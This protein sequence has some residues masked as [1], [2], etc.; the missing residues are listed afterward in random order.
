MS[1]QS[2]KSSLVWK[3]FERGS[4]QAVQFLVGII[5]ARL[6]T[7]SVFGEVALLTIFVSIAN[8]FVLSGLS[9]AIV[10]KKEL[11]DIEVT[12]V[13]WYCMCV[14]II[15][16]AILFFSSESIAS[17]YKMTSLSLHLKVM[18]LSLFPGALNAIQIACLSKEMQFKKQ[19]YCNTVAVLFSGSLGLYMAYTGYGA[20]ALIFQQ[21]SYQVVACVVMWLFVK[22]RPSFVFSIKKT[23]P[24]LFYGSKLLFSNITDTV[25]RNL[26]SLVIGKF[27]NSATL[28]F[29]NKGKMFPMVVSDNIDGSIQSV[30]LPAFSKHQDNVEDLKAYLRKTI[31]LST[32]L[33][34]PSMLLLAAASKSVIGICLG[35]AWMECVPFV[36]LFCILTMLFPIQTTSVQALNAIGLSGITMRYRIRTRVIGVSLLF[37]FLYLFKTPYSIVFASIFTE[38]CGILILIPLNKKYLTYSFLELSKDLSSPLLCS[39]LMFICIYSLTFFINNYYILLISQI[40]LGVIIYYIFAKML[41]NDNLDYLLYIVKGK[42]CH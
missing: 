9:T 4:V 5:I 23:L 19:F 33:F 20:W 34:Y 13:F 10:Q 42:M 37:F 3:F 25:Y 7:P 8:V 15:A 27:F 22:W 40:A 29:C 30:M 36:F 38:V 14:A 24:L 26:E 31:S 11:D 2:V 21:L 1:S 17:F 41:K 12:S 35:E 28:A 39:I 16:Y 18:A 6:L 32:F